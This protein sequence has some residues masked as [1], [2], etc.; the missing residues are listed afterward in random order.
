MKTVLLALLMFALLLVTF[1][2]PANATEPGWSPIIIPTGSYRDEIKSMPIEQR[3]YR[4]GHFYGNTVRRMHYHG[5]I[6]PRPLDRPA[7]QSRVPTVF[8]PTNPIPSLAPSASGR[9][10]RNAYGIRRILT[11]G[12]FGS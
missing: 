12:R 7:T 3:P 4:P 8:G 1:D 5:E 6:L 9:D 10:T 11:N 2:S